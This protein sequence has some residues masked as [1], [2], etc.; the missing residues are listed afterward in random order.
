MRCPIFQA[1]LSAPL[2]S[3]VQLLMELANICSLG[4]ILWAGFLLGSE[5][6][7]ARRALEPDVQEMFRCCAEGRGFVGKYWWLVDGWTR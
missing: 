3:Y 7:S 6:C 1:G 4:N 2:L 5:L